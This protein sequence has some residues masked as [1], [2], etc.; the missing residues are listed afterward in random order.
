MIRVGD[1]L[2]PPFRRILSL[3]PTRTEGPHA[4]REREGRCPFVSRAVFAAPCAKPL[5]VPD[6]LCTQIHNTKSHIQGSGRARNLG[7]R[8]YYFENDPLVEQRLAEHMRHV[9]ADPSLAQADASMRQE[10][11]R[12]VS[13]GMVVLTRGGVV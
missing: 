12:L 6:S 4:R 13:E 7:S 9:A 10:T 2:T 1:Q 8:V 5:T 3:T 11:Q